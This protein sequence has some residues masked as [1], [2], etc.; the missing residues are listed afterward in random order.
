MAAPLI[1]QNLRCESLR[2]T[3]IAGGFTVQVYLQESHASEKIYGG[4]GEGLLSFAG[5]RQ[6]T[7]VH[8]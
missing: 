5:F 1:I 3:L 8:R 6:D 2:N 4:I 7:L